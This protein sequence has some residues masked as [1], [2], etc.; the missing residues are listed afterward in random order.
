MTAT[1]FGN[2]LREWRQLRGIS[3]LDLAARAEVSQRHISFLETGRSR[4]SREMV[5][6]LGQ[7]LEVPLREQNLL[8][9]AAGLAPAYRDTSLDNLEGVS[10]V[11][12]FM[13]EAHE[14]NLAIVVDRQWNLV[15]AN[16][17]ATAFTARLFP[18]PPSWIT[19]PVNIMRLSL[20]PEGTRR[21]MTGWETT[22]AALL[23]R[24]ERDA[25]SHPHDRGLQE[26]LVEVHGYSGIS[27]LPR[28]P[29]AGAGDLLVPT[30][31]VID[32]EE[33]SMFTTIAII[34]DAHDLTLAELR[35]ET[36]WPMDPVSAQRWSRIFG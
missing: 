10:R 4:P 1:V 15:K 7:V 26:L 35:L 12:D 6:H 16:R 2:Q 31:Y 33:I 17:V 23:R 8:L 27:D 9:T 25:A 34:G 36:F 5:V 19:P 13:L 29:A 20:H 18:E 11:L 32:G 24:L 14:P 21:H 3:Q 30:T 28:A 22:A